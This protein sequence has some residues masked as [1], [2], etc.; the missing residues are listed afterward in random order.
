MKNNKG[1]SI[2]YR[3]DGRTEIR[4]TYNG[5]QKSFYLPSLKTEIER[6]QK[7][8]TNN[9]KKVLFC[10]YY[11]NWFEYYKKPFVSDNTQK[12]IE[13]TFNNN[14]LPYIGNKEMV[15][16]KTDDVQKI[17]IRLKDK[18]RTQSLTFCY[19]KAIFQ[20]ACKLLVIKVN[21]CNNAVIRKTQTNVRRAFTL[22]EQQQIISYLKAKKHILTNLFLFYLYT[23]VRRMEALSLTSNDVDRV[24]N[25]I[26]IKGTKT[27][28]SDRYITT[29]ADVIALIPEKVKPFDYLPNFVTKSFKRVLR[30]LKID[31]AC[32]NCLRHTFATRCLESGINIKTVQLWLGHSSY[33]L[34]ANTYSH[35]QKEF[36]QSE[37]KKL[38]QSMLKS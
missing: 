18:P 31:N 7:E 19:L 22:V 37:V 13:C 4:I 8:I 35:I 15:S 11:K 5:V 14:I 27:H 23:G 36:L 21:P 26:H 32:L 16:I 29:S 17:L 12:S 9:N 20:Q 33:N 10:D 30:A 1:F 28:T 2:R 34:T 38:D 3:K 6:M 24:N 25:V